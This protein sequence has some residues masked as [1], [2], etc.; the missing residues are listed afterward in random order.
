MIELDAL[1]LEVEEEGPSYLADLNKAPDFIDEPPVEVTD[2]RVS[3]IVVSV[4]IDIFRRLR[5]RKQSSRRHSRMGDE[6]VEWTVVIMQC[7]PTPGGLYDV[8]VN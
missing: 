4:F 8:S 3:T 6:K 5:R 7:T 1:A 2:V